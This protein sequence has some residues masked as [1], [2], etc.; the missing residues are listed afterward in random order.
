[1][2]LSLSRIATIAF[3]VIAIGTAALP[4]VSFAADTSTTGV[5]L[6]NP[7]GSSDVRVIIGQV[8]K[9]F[10]GLSGSIALVMIIYG[11]FLWLT[12]NGNPE[13]IDKG[14]KVLVW[15]VIGLAV[16]FSAFTITNAIITGIA[17]GTTSSSA[18]TTT[19]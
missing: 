11:G 17:T 8:I 18:T 19:P 14:R 13:K 16:I 5:T 2:R 7:L 3:A 4:S 9:A 12:S 1:M 15:A 10:L 6:V